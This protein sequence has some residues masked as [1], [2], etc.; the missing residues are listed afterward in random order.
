MQHHQLSLTRRFPCESL[1]PCSHDGR[2]RS[3]YGIHV[4]DGSVRIAHE[5]AFV[6]NSARDFSESALEI[7]T[8]ACNQKAIGVKYF[9]TRTMLH[10]VSFPSLPRAL[11]EPRRHSLGRLMSSSTA[12]LLTV[13]GALIIVLALLI[14]FHH[15][16]NATKGYRLRTLERARTDLLLEQEVV[17]MQIAKSNSLESLQNDPQILAMQKPTKP[18]YVRADASVAEAATGTN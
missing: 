3:V 17:N 8:F 7:R 6:S 11:S 2:E 18:K 16:M 5:E 10:S 4:E 9:P 14:L 15:N 12:L 1:F 13:I